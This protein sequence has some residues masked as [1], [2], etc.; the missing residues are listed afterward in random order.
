MTVAH[1]LKRKGHTVTVAAPDAP[2]GRICDMLME[3]KIG[4]IVIVDDGG[5]VLGIISERDLVRAISIHGATA[6]ARPVSTIMTRHVVSA[7]ETERVEDVMRKMTEGRF[8]HVP[9][10]KDGRLVGIVSIGDVVKHRLSELEAEADAL[11]YYIR[12]G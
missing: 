5:R 11:R 3:H 4:A 12:A 10:M 1:L 7:P 9:V 6:L 8:R 2:L